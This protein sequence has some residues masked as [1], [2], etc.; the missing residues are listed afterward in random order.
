MD[1]DTIF[2]ILGGTL[3]AVALVI[4]FLG[5]RRES[6]PPSKAL[7]SAVI[8]LFALL[9]AGTAAFAVASARDEQAHREAEEAE[10]AE[11]AAATEETAQAEPGASAAQAGGGEA[12]G[13]GGGA[14][15]AATTT[16]ELAADETDL[17]FDETTLQANPG[18][19]TIEFDNP[20]IVPH[21][22]AVQ[23]GGKPLA[24]SET[25]TQSGTSVTADL[26]AG[27]Y[28]F[29]CTV[30]GHAE[31]GMRGILQVG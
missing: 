2:Y 4:S 19:V 6:F 20:A 8:A 21:N 5:L 18:A 27:R 13:G 17:A 22:V 11:E 12:A 26:K 29:L 15:A 31:A 23:Q 16:L 7:M 3:A 10:H 30:P 9:V 1:T 25:V 14:G 24:E 28:E